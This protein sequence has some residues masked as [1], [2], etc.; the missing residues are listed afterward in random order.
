MRPQRPLPAGCS[1][2]RSRYAEARTSTSAVAAARHL[3]DKFAVH[4]VGSSVPWW[5]RH[6]DGTLVQPWR[7]PHRAIGVE[8]GFAVPF[9]HVR[10]A[11]GVPAADCIRPF[12]VRA[13][14]YFRPCAPACSGPCCAP[15]HRGGADAGDNASRPVPR[16]IPTSC[17]SGR[18]GRQPIDAPRCDARATRRRRAGGHA[19]RPAIAARKY[20]SP[21]R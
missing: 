16:S 3:L 1:W 8:V 5:V 7:S 9:Q 18:D 2:E 10:D 11:C 20:G 4:D 17:R 15:A 14:Q 21:R 13:D 12:R 6:A 19:V